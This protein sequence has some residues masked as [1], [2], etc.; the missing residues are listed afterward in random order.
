MQASQEK[1][2]SVKMIVLGA[3][4]TGKSNLIRKISQ[5]QFSP[6]SGN[7]IDVDFLSTSAVAEGQRFAVQLW[8]EPKE[9][10][11]GSGRKAE[12]H[13]YR[14]AN[15]ALICVDITDRLSAENAKKIL[16]SLRNRDDNLIKIIVGTKS[17]Q[18]IDRKVST[19]FLQS[20]GEHYDAFYRE[21]SAKTG[22]GL[23]DLIQSAVQRYGEENHLIQHASLEQTAR[24][25]P[26]QD[27]LD[28]VQQLLQSYAQRAADSSLHYGKAVQNTLDFIEQSPNATLDEVKNQLKSELAEQGRPWSNSN[29]K[30]A[31][32]IDKAF[33]APKQPGIRGFMQRNKTSDSWKKEIEQQAELQTNNEHRPKGPRS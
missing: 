17:D 1:S 18:E 9:T 27:G 13:F 14:G 2:P 12:N 5:G 22:A 31:K 20:I 29:S 10:T 33:P 23:E 21:C 16:H 7:N 11:V 4:G 28:K 30:I 25:E 32:L 6:A 24:Q 19:D 15:V 3:G 26:K 8:D